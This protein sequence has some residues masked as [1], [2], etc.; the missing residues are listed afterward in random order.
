MYSKL[1][2]TGMAA[3]LVTGVT[4]LNATVGVAVVAAGFGL[5]VILIASVAKVEFEQKAFAKRRV[6][7]FR[8]VRRDR[9]S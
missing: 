7:T 6:W 4:L 1:V 3:S 8:I 5:A 2:R 9:K